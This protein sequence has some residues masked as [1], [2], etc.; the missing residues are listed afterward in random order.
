MVAPDTLATGSFLLQRLFV[1]VGQYPLDHHQWD[2]L[3]LTHNSASECQTRGVAL[4]EKLTPAPA[5]LDAPA[6]LPSLPVHDPLTSDKKGV[7]LP[8]TQSPIGLPLGWR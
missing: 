4:Q 7:C 6:Q 3:P 8:Y 2:G 1:Q 5:W